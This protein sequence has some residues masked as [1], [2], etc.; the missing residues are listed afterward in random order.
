ME[1]SILVVPRFHFFAPDVIDLKLHHT[2]PRHWGR[3]VLLVPADQH[4][5][6]PK[7]YT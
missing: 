1:E 3:F 2:Y 5:H 6:I 7:G 4:L